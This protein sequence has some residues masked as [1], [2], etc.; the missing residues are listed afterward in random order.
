MK[1]VMLVALFLWIFTCASTEAVS[2][3][4]VIVGAIIAGAGAAL[5]WEAVDR[6]LFSD[7]GDVQAALGLVMV[8]VGT[9]VV[10]WGL[11]DDGKSNGV[12]RQ[13]RM[14]V[15]PIQLG[16]VPR[17]NGFAAGAVFRW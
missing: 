13:Q 2:K 16:F 4:K 15:P 11:F 3:K 5:T 1:K 9:G 14:T 7:C 8:G 12:I 17:K 6:C 10:I